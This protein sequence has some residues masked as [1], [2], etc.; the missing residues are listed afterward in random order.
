MKWQIKPSRNLPS[1]I[2]DDDDDNND[3]DNDGDGDDDIDDDK[4]NIF[5]M[6]MIF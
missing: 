6:R 2:K 1:N 5:M 3:D 4:I